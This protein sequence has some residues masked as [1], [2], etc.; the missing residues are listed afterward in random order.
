MVPI[1]GTS[2]MGLVP[3][4]RGRLWIGSL[5]N[6]ALIIS[7]GT[8]INQKTHFHKKIVKSKLRDTFFKLIIAFFKYIFMGPLT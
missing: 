7:S 6:W 5:I 8:D 3:G 1:M 2:E 4:G